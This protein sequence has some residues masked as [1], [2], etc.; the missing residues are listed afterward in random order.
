[1]RI[2]SPI[3]LVSPCQLL[4]EAMPEPLPWMRKPKMSHVTKMRVIHRAGMP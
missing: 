2:F 1:M 3:S 4:L